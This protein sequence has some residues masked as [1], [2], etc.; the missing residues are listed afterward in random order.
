MIGLSYGGMYTL[1]TA[2]ADTRIKAAVSSCWFNDRY[3]Y[4]WEDWTYFNGG[5]FLDAEVADLILPRK[6]YIEAGLHDELFTANAARAE[7]ER[8]KKYAER[9]HAESALRFKLFDGGHE[10]DK[11]SDEGIDFLVENI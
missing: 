3:E 4:N 5:R 11:T 10:L 8:L 6:L 9:E 7:F 1:Y 2:A